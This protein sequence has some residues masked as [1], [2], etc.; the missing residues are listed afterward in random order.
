MHGATMLVS[1]FLSS[2]HWSLLNEISN[3]DEQV[4]RFTDKVLNGMRQ[5]IPLHTSTQS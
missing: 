2:V 5:H 3:A 1:G 4:S